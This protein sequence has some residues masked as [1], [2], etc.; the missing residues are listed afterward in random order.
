MRHT[1]T[2][3]SWDQN[4]RYWIN[5]DQGGQRDMSDAVSRKYRAAITHQVTGAAFTL[6]PVGQEPEADPHTLGVPVVSE[7][8]QLTTRDVAPNGA[9]RRPIT[10]ADYRA[11]EIGPGDVIQ[12]PEDKVWVLVTHKFTDTEP[13][14]DEQRVAFGLLLSDSIDSEILDG[15]SGYTVVFVTT[16]HPGR[17]TPSVISATTF[18]LITTQVPV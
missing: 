6:T 4:S 14:T 7:T 10:S 8:F 11:G 17:T 3:W 15:V 18:A 9:T 13:P 16:P 5:I 12:H 1:H 2:L